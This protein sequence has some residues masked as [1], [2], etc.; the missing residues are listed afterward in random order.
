MLRRLG[1]DTLIYGAGD[2]LSKLIAFAAFP[3]IA[4]CLTPA[5]FGALELALTAVSLAG[6]VV[7]SGLNNAV[8]RFYWDPESGPE[9]RRDLVTTGMATLC[10]FGSV[11]AILGLLFLSNISRLA[12][13][14]GLEI[15]STGIAAALVSIPSNQCLQYILDTIRLHLAP[16]RYLALS[17]ISKSTLALASVAVVWHGYGV[18]G[19]LISLTVV[20]V[21]FV[22]V[23]LLLIRR[24]LV[25]RFNLPVAR[26]LVGFGAPFIF[27]GLAYWI[28]AS[29][30]RWMLAWLSSVEETGIYSVAHRFASVVMMLSLAFG[31]AWSPYAMKVRADDP[32][33]YRA[34]YARVG[35][36]L[37]YGMLAA[38]SA[39]ALF[40]GELLALLLPAAYAGAALPLAILCFGV[41]LQSTQQ[42]TA[43]GI[44]LERQTH[45]FARMAWITALA[46]L[47]G[48]LLLIP[49]LGAT[50]AALATLLS[51]LILTAGYLRHTQR[52]H[53][54]PIPVAPLL[55]VCLAGIALGAVA[56]LFRSAAVEPGPVAGKLIALVALLAAGFPG[57]MRTRAD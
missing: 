50:G 42:V 27:A 54:L 14:H 28:F 30:D 15:G 19:I 11:A 13:S 8:Q 17:F 18:N 55:R 39:V 21:V 37:L 6:I 7:N 56:L 45:L 22:P 43:V 35:V 52:L 12:H 4:A 36:L 40:S 9:R 5:D 46:N 33:G 48:N 1:R 24:D 10:L 51:Y 2:F 49:R 3:V 34:L 38:A 44:S 32:A 41:A 16:T 57:R 31:Q 20:S 53:P 29:T 26:E 23:G 25:P 47:A